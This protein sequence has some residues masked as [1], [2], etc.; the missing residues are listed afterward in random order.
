MT[1]RNRNQQHFPLLSAKSFNACLFLWG[2][3][4]CRRGDDMVTQ[5]KRTDEPGNRVNEHKD[6]ETAEGDDPC[7]CKETSKMTP[8]EL[9]RLMMDDLAFWKKAK[10]D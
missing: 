8:R 6:P 1:A 9:L 3:V 4:I 2:E 5:K 7:R 10:K